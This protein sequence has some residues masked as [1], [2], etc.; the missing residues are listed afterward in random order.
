MVA[1]AA[2]VVVVVVVVAVVVV[3]VILKC[4]FIKPISQLPIDLNEAVKAGVSVI[5]RSISTGLCDVTDHV[6]E[7][8]LPVL[9][10]VNVVQSAAVSSSRD[11]HS[12]SRLSA[13][14]IPSRTFR[15]KAKHACMNSLIENAKRLSNVQMK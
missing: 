8:R 13:G 4:H 15:N 9:S 12:S 7:I 14:S 10:T 6:T 5:P 1:A 2:V 11:V 3:A